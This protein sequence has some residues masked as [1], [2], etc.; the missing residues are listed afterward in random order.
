G[1]PR[2]DRTPEAGRR[3]RGQAMAPRPPPGRERTAPADGPR[4]GPGRGGGGWPTPHP[5]PRSGAH[6]TEA[7]VST[8]APALVA[9]DGVSKRFRQGRRD[10]QALQEV[11]F[12]VAP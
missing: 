7:A 3:G 4:G 12:G 2:R 10:V 1:P 9:L 5:R 11:T 6:V 8:E